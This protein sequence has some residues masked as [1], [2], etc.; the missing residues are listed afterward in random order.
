M[1]SSITG[2]ST[3]D[4][5]AKITY[6]ATTIANS[7][8]RLKQNLEITDLQASIVSTRQKNVR[9]AISSSLKVSS[10]FLAGSYMRDTLIAPLKEADIDVF[11]ILDSE[12]Y[13][14]YNG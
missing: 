7:F 4:N 8:S 13:H 11:I 14:N 5:F 1:N 2:N 3:F 10:D 12:Y 6:M 9:D